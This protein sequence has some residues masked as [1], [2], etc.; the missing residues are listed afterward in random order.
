MNAVSNNYHNMKRINSQV[1]TLF[2]SFEMP[3]E[4]ILKWMLVQYAGYVLISHFSVNICIYGYL[5][6]KIQ[7]TVHPTCAALRARS[8]IETESS[9]PA[10]LG[11]SMTCKVYCMRLLGP[12]IHDEKFRAVITLFHKRHLIFV[13]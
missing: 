2:C 8:L 12:L 6:Y 11:Q 5:T 7:T 9:K 10:P 3:E 13:Q 1:R 4:K